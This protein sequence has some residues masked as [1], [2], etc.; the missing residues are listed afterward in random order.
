MVEDS[1]R[2]LFGLRYRSGVDFAGDEATGRLRL[3]LGDVVMMVDC[4]R[5][6]AAAE[7]TRVV[8]IM[9]ESSF[10]PDLW[11]KEDRSDE[12]DDVVDTEAGAG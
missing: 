9:A 10:D 1:A 2:R 5:A 7:G 11:L 6:D 12:L 8:E 4:G 3:P